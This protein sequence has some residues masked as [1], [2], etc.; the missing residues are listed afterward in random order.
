M[1]KTQLPAIAMLLI[2]L[3]FTDPGTGYAVGDNGTILN[4]KDEG[5]TWNSQSSG[6]DQDLISV[7]SPNINSVCVVAANGMILKT[8]DGCTSWDADIAAS[9]FN[10]KDF[11]FMNGSSLPNG[12]YFVKLSNNE[13]IDFGKFI[14][15]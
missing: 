4:T 11:Y 13:K 6:T 1:K 10:L 15:E 3:N 8:T 7:S 2:G 9:G 12:I 5:A 14:K